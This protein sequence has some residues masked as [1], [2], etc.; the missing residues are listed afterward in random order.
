MGTP[1]VG[2]SK[3]VASAG[4]RGEERSDD[5]APEPVGDEDSEVPQRDADH[6]PDEDGQVILRV[7]ARS[8]PP[9]ADAVVAGGARRVGPRWCA[10]RPRGQRGFEEL[11]TAGD[12]VADRFVGG[13][14]VVERTRPVPKQSGESRELGNP[15]RSAARRGPRA[16]RSS[17][18][19]LRRRALR[20]ACAVAAVRGCAR[21]SMRAYGAEARQRRGAITACSLRP[22]RRPSP[23]GRAAARAP[24]FS[25]TSGSCR[26]LAG[27]ARRHGAA[28]P[29]RA[30]RSLPPRAAHA[31][32]HGPSASAPRRAGNDR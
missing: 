15:D 22:A 11:E 27:S 32:A 30:G 23:V 13:G 2:S 26:A 29:C 4:E 19:R 12:R 1:G 17:R 28:P 8:G 21:L 14:A 31:T 16:G 25:S 24:A 3:P 10:S 18:A 5:G 6:H 20:R 7:R 9:A